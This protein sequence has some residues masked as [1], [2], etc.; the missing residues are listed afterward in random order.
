MLEDIY[1]LRG[2][3]ALSRTHETNYFTDGHRG[4]AIIAAYYL[5][6]E[7]EPE[8]GAADHIRALIDQHWTHTPLCAPMPDEAPEPKGI[9]R[10]TLALIEVTASAPGV[11]AAKAQIH[12]IKTDGGDQ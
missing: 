11:A 10:I 12:A 7:V 3:D 6:R 9:Q 1:L 2:L 5:C 8:E 4:A